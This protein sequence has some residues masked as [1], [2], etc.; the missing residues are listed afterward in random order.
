MLLIDLFETANRLAANGQKA[1]NRAI[2]SAI[3]GGS[4]TTISQALRRWREQQELRTEPPIERAPMPAPMPAAVADAMYDAVSRLWRAAQTET[5]AEL[6]QLTQA[7]NAR[8]A[9]AHGERDEA[10]AELQ[11]TVEELEQPA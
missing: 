6:D 7:M 5:Q 10:L 3:D 9:E 4:M 1:S 2:W 8:V 11:T